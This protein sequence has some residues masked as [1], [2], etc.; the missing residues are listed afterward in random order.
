[1]KKRLFFFALAIV[2]MNF[3][4][5]QVVADFEDGTTGPL[6]LHVMGCGDFD[7]DAIHPVDE[8]FMVIDNPDASGLNTS[9]KVLKFIR[10]GTD[11]GGMPWGGFWANIDPAIDV[12][13][14]KYA[15][16]LVWKPAISPLKFKLEGST[17][18][19]T[20]SLNT[21]SA[22][23]EWVDIVFDF[24]TLTGPYAVMSLMPDFEDPY[25]TAADTEIFIDNILFNDDPTPFVPPILVAVKF[26]VDMSYQTTIGNFDPN[27]D[28]M[29]VAGSFNGWSGD[30]SHLTLESDGIY[31]I[32]VEGLAVA[33][34][35][36]FKF[37]INGDWATSEFPS[38]GPNRTYTVV[39][40][41]NEIL[42]WYNDEEPVFGGVLADFEN[43]TWG[44]LTPHVMGC[45]DYDNDA[46][47]PVNET[48]MIVDNPDA[49]G[50]NTTSKVLKF[51]RRG[52]DNGG[53]AWGGFWASCDPAVNATDNKYIHVMVWKPMI[54][55]LKFKMEGDPTLEIESINAQTE[56]EG[57]QD[58]VFDFSSLTGDYGVVAFMPDFVDP[59]ATAADVDMYIDNI[60]ITNSPNPISGIWNNKY[61]NAISLYPNPCNTSVTID[62]TKDM[63]SV[64]I[65]NLMGQKVLSMENV[66]K[67]TVNIN[68]SFLNQ[69]LYFITLTDSNNKTSSAKMMKN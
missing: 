16:V 2:S 61:D 68:V 6:T 18:L 10:R 40:G 46:I 22:T 29:D 51:I 32:T 12:T 5:A 3:L 34:L 19:E 54:S 60:Q 37:R 44:I 38:G 21:Q 35:L 30:D 9:S 62:L 24:T 69:G 14:N 59:L 1:M 20:A 8:T 15:H 65:S 41:T 48:F 58:I 49:S 4:S 28:Y 53:M 64:V 7:N 43:D 17:T 42:V 25:T 55:P 33:S 36:E 13:V 56:T 52:T 57:W 39:E 27:T 11:N 50:I 26:S 47:H 31:S 63:N 67:G 45:G 66:Q 23:N